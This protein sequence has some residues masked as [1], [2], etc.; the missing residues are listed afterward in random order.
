MKHYC[1]HCRRRLELIVAH[2]LW[3]VHKACPF[4][5]RIYTTWGAQVFQCETPALHVPLPLRFLEHVVG[6]IGNVIPGP[7]HR[8][9]L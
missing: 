3:S 1:T 7:H 8:G 9:L 6:P 2:N 4:C 5:K